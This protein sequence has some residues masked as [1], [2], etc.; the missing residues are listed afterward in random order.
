[1]FVVKSK[2]QEVSWLIASILLLFASAIV[3]DFVIAPYVAQH[4]SGPGAVLI[5]P[6]WKLL[7]WIIPTF[8]YIQFVE[9][10]NPLMYLKLTTHPLK[11]LAWGLFGCIFVIA[12]EVGNLL[13]YPFH[14]SQS[15]D[16]WVNVILLVGLMEEIPFRGLL[17]QKLQSWFGVVW[18]ILL[19]T[20]LFVCIHIPLW[21]STGQSFSQILFEMIL[22]FLVGI[23]ACIV[24]EIS[25]SLWSSVIVHTF[26][27]FL[28]SII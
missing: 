2:A 12:L 18:A 5:E 27:N 1:M 8:L 24:L 22:I 25:G 16:T 15:L 20:L 17:F 3:R 23:L 14:L 19:S 9:H 26:Y 11:G 28:N 10:Q 4:L 7:F 6:I 13:R 21:M